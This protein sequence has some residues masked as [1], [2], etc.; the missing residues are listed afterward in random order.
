MQI[1]WSA[2]LH[3][4]TVNRVWRRVSVAHCYQ[5]IVCSKLRKTLVITQTHTGTQSD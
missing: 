2:L 3:L 1:I 5:P 4:C